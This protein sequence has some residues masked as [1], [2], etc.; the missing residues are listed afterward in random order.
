MKKLVVSFILLFSLPVSAQE[1]IITTVFDGPLSGGIPK[2]VELKVL[3]DITD[4]STYGLGG[5]NNG[6]G[7][8]GE[9]FT[10]PSVSATAGEYLYV[11]SEA[12]GFTSFFG[13]EPDYTSFAM[14]INGDDA[15]ELFFNDTV[16]DLFGDPNTDGTDQEWEYVDGWASRNSNVASP[17]STFN[18]S[19]WIFSGPNAL[20]GET[21][22]ATAASMIPINGSGPT[23]PPGPDLRTIAEIQGNPTNYGSNSFGDTDVSPLNGT[24]VAIEAIVVGDFQ[25]NDSDGSRNL[26]GFYLQEETADED[27]DATSSEGIFVFDPA[28]LVDVSIGDL[29]RVE[30][31]VGQWFGETQ[32]RNVTYIEILEEGDAENLLNL[33][34]PAQITLSD[35]TAVTL[36]RDGNYQPDLESYEGMLVVVMETLQIIEQF[37]LDR[38]NEIKLAAGDRPWQFTQFNAP[39]VTLY[40]AHLQAVGARTITYDDGLNVQNFSIDNLDGFAPYNEATAPRMGDTIYELAGVLDYKWAGNSASD[41]TWRIRSPLDGLNHFTSTANGDSPNPRPLEAPVIDALLKVASFNVLN[42]FTTLDDGNSLTAVGL[43]PRGADDLSRF[44]VNP[45]TLE[46][47]RQ[48]NKLVNAIVELDADVLGLVEVENFFDE[49]DDGST[50]IEYLT[51]AVNAA[52]GEQ[53]IYRTVYPNSQFVGTD[54]IA[55]GFIYNSKKVRLVKR[56]FVSVLDDSVAATLPEFAN[57][58][59]ATDPIFNGIATNRASLAASF[60]RLRGANDVFTV[61]VNH[62]K[63]KGP[64]GID[65]PNSAVYD[66]S[67]LNNDQLDGAGY[68][69]LRRLNAARAVDAWIKTDPTQVNDEDVIILGD[70]NAYAQEDPIRYLTN[71]AGY[72]NVVDPDAYSF[73][74]DGQIGTLDY[75]LVSRGM[76]E[77]LV[78]AAGWHINADEAEALDYNVDFGR[79]QSYYDDATPTRNSDH[80]PLVAGFKANR[81]N[82]K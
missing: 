47:D 51:A 35:N 71:D 77:K 79:K 62:F 82:R 6:G 66:P 32:L 31:T 70:L 68:W 60:S 55:V 3:D 42:F 27:G 69:N 41:S 23:N 37:Q 64:S 52:L 22:N 17:S 65:N 14:S 4:L 11:A 26:D 48:L 50:P 53:R 25:D 36:N 20:D 5:A 7:T 30:G 40:E 1:L 46:F 9:E 34:T 43:E 63:S 28:T 15:I 18:I 49:E 38:F 57:H 44:G 54:A 19:E 24:V 39:D 58:D 21:S 67:S 72:M 75:M 45:P 2:G 33:V 13:F 59:F 16:V 61:V 10:F 76:A 8:D 80:D 78:R 12:V 73:V 74:F 56:E 29:V 81:D